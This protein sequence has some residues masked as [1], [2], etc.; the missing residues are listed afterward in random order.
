MPTPAKT[1]TMSERTLSIVAKVLITVVPAALALMQARV[2][3][4]ARAHQAQVAATRTAEV[5]SATGYAELAKLVEE[6][7]VA[8]RADHD[9]ILQL[10]NHLSTIESLLVEAR[11]GRRAPAAKPWVVLPP[12]DPKDPPMSIDPSFSAAL[13]PP[14]PALTRPRSWRKVQEAV[15]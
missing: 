5:Q 9:Q 10:E 6:L 8:R 11:A 13:A 3:F 2:E 12:E 7:Q 1:P 15:W 4:K 14:A